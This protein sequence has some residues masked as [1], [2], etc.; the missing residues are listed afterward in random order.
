[1]G[2]NEIGYWVIFKLQD[3]G[4]NRTRVSYQL[5][6]T[7]PFSMFTD[8]VAI[9]DRLKVITNAVILSMTIENR[10]AENS[11]TPAPAESQIEAGALLRVKEAE[12]GHRQHTLRIPSPH[13]DIFLSSSGHGANIVDPDNQDVLDFV[14]EFEDGEAGFL[15]GKK[16]GADSGFV[17]GSRATQK[18]RRG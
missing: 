6:S 5:Q 15:P 18:S 16:A 10:Y 1:M 9:F 17:S 13:P 4:E 3:G 7:D 14:A 2:Q 12:H 8:A 11:Y